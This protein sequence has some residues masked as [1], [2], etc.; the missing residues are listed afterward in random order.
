M[1]KYLLFE[2]KYFKLFLILNY[3]TKTSF[4]CFFLRTKMLNVY[5]DN[6]KGECLSLEI[7]YLTLFDLINSG[8][9]FLF[10]FTIRWKEKKCGFQRKVTQSE[11]QFYWCFVQYFFRFWQHTVTIWWPWSWPIFGHTDSSSSTV[12]MWRIFLTRF[13]FKTS[14]YK[15]FSKYFSLKVLKG[16][17]AFIVLLKYISDRKIEVLL[18]IF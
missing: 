11:T 4:V 17:R 13:P 14:I 8:Q 1:L 5:L 16:K 15:K 6:P 9:Y 18:F 10:I 7:A 12:T 3:K 2:K